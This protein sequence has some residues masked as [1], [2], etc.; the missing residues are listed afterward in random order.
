MFDCHVHSNISHDSVAKVDEFI[1]YAEKK[2][3]DGFA[4]TDHADIGVYSYEDV[5]EKIE[6]SFR[7]CE[8]SKKKYGNKIQIFSGIEFGENRWRQELTDKVINELPF[9]IVL[10]SVHA[11]TYEGL[12]DF[13]SRIDFKSLDNDI[14]ISYM[15]QYFKDYLFNLEVADMDVA[16]HLTCP[17]RYITG[18]HGIVVNLEEFSEVISEIL[19]LII[20]RDIAFEVNT[21]CVG[22]PYNEL[23]PDSRII[24]QYVKMGGRKIILASDAHKSEKIGQHFDEAIAVLKSLGIENAYY[25]KNRKAISYKL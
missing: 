21:S 25:Y 13:Y 16:T 15:R 9:D 14:I 19:K 22:S 4:I 24:N 10:S 8:D 6:K 5:F 2:G 23:M 1:S 3:I 12:T 17:L 7:L 18:K 20:K 11:V